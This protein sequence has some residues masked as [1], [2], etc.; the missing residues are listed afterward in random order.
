MEKDILKRKALRALKENKNAHEDEESRLN[1]NEDSDVFTKEVKP[2]STF[3][4]LGGVCKNLCIKIASF[5][6][7]WIVT[8]GLAFVNIFVTVYKFARYGTLAI[9]RFFKQLGHKFKYN[10]KYGKLS[11][12]IFGAGALAHGQI[13]NGIMYLVFQVGYILFMIFA[14]AQAFAGIWNLGVIRI[15]PAWIYTDSTPDFQYSVDNSL[16]LL[17]TGLFVL[18]SMFVFIYIWYRSINSG[19]NNYRISKFNEYKNIHEKCIPMSNKIDEYIENKYKQFYFAKSNELLDV[20]DNENSSFKNAYNSYFNIKLVLSNKLIK[21]ELTQLKDEFLAQA[22]NKFETDYINYVFDETVADSNL[23]YKNHYAL[24]NKQ[25]KQMYLCNVL[26]FKHQE[27]YELIKNDEKLNEEQKEALINKKN[28]INKKKEHKY[29]DKAN[30]F[31]KAISDRTKTHSPFASKLSRINYNTYAKF[32]SY[33]NTVSKYNVDIRFYRAYKEINNYYHSI[34]GNY[35]NENESNIAKRNDV[36]AELIQKLDSIN[37]RYNEIYAKKAQILENIKAIELDLKNEITRLKNEKIARN[38]DENDEYV[39]YL[40]QH[41]E[42][43][44]YVGQVVQ[45][46]VNVEGLTLV[47]IAKA[48]YQERINKLDGQYNSFASDKLLK[49]LQKEEIKLSTKRSKDDIK[50]L[51]TNFDEKT[52]AIEETI[53]HMLVDY[54]FDYKYARESIEIIQKDLSEEEVSTILY[55]L[56]NKKDEFI[57]SNESTK[58]VGKSKSFKDQIRSLFNDKFHITI[59]ALPVLGAVIFSIIPLIFSILIA[60]TNYDKQHLIGVTPF[61]WTGFDTFIR[62]FEGTDPIYGAIGEAIGATFLWTFVWAIFATFT[63]Y[64]LGIVVALMINKDGIRLKKLWRTLFVLTIAVPQFISLSTIAKML[65]TG[66][67]GVINNIYQSATGV[68]LGFAESIKNNALVTKII[69]IIVN[70]WVG[71]PYTILST[72]GILMNIPKDLYESSRIDGAGPATQ[73][74]KITMPYIL[75]VTGPSLITNFI[76]NFNNFGVIFFLTGGAPKRVGT[77]SMAPGYTDL[78]ITY[79]YTL[80]TG[81]TYKYY[82]VASA[83]GIIIFIVCSFISII[84]Y[85]KTGAVAKEDQFQ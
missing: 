58:F 16:L 34:G 75:F 25:E 59:L 18:L 10:D 42:E 11:F 77:S 85:N 70:V 68:S 14:G 82:N 27:E 7:S 24:L 51:K 57:A 74:F 41:L 79:I 62:M 43:L 36:S 53:N 32:N 61:Q 73:F 80:V 71:I 31:A 64:F 83:L 45:K 48:L 44:T 1:F 81:E 17:I 2:M 22:D 67:M 26:V 50:F 72:T 35:V 8:I 19:Y 76:G 78:F 47:E 4:Y 65:Q 9:G 37:A 63:N 84:M 46:D 30:S 6:W 3:E 21:K 23:Y 33:F 28:L 54:D 5:F 66:G 15:N 60:F 20:L 39:N 13:I 12:F 52:Y 29:E 56:E 55:E 38:F 69:I 40:K 49:S